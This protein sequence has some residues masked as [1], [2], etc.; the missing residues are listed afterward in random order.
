MVPGFGQRL[1]GVLQIGAQL[2]RC[3]GFTVELEQQTPAARMRIGHHSLVLQ[4]AAAA[5]VDDRH[6][7][8]A[9]RQPLPRLDLL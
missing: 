1:V 4:A 3:V 7:R 9:G 8:R 5:D 6:R 2:Q